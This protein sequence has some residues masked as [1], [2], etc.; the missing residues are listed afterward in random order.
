MQNIRQKGQSHFCRH[1]NWDSPKMFGG[2]AL[3]FE[4]DGYSK[5]VALRRVKYAPCLFLRSG[6][7]TW[8]VA[9]MT[10]TIPTK[11][12]GC[13]RNNTDSI[14]PGKCDWCIKSWL[15]IRHARLNHNIQLGHPLK[16]DS[17]LKPTIKWN[18]RESGFIFHYKYMACRHKSICRQQ[19][20]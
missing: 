7:D 5:S 8:Q 11:K 6:R 13:G 20:I 19:F 1:K 12:G 15:P 14:I 3:S 10:I 16:V 4:G 2:I 9:A 17:C 18:N